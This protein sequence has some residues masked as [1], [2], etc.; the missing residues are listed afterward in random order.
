MIMPPPLKCLFSFLLLINITSI[1]QNRIAVWL[2]NNDRTALFQQQTPLVFSAANATANAI[3]VDDSKTFQQIDGF[4]FA[5]T[6]GSAM[7]IIRMNAAARNNLL[8]H[9]FDTTGNAIGISYLRL[10]IGASDLNE[11]VFSYDDIAGDTTLEH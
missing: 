6:G 5:L 2:T 11:K 10:S 9:L 7:H 1:A 4:G 3:T 8:H